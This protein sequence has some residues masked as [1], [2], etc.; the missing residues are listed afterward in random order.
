[1]RNKPKIPVSYSQKDYKSQPLKESL[2]LLFRNKNFVLF[3]VCATCIVGFFN[4]YGTILN[5]YLALYNV[6]DDEASY[7]SAAAN[8]F[9][10]ATC[11]IVSCILDSTKKFKPMMIILN[12]CGLIAMI[13]LT[14]LLEFVE[15]N[16]FVLCIILFTFIIGFVTPIYTTGMDYVAEMTYPVGESISGG[17]IM[18]FNQIFGIIG[19]LIADAFIDKVGDKRY[20]TNI[21]SIIIFTISIISIFFIEERLLRNEKENEKVNINEI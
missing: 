7:T 20:L 11:L 14:V 6:K 2:K 9:G 17:L 21:M 1:M 3:L 18:C 8:G 15:K 19:I 4:I 16:V 10:I 13:I 12:I 5:P